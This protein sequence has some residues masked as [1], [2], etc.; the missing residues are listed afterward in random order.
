MLGVLFEDAFSLWVSLKRK[1]DGFLFVISTE[2]IDALNLVLKS[3]ENLSK[4]GDFWFT[5]SNAKLVMSVSR[6][7][8]ELA[9]FLSENPIED[10]LI[11]FNDITIFDSIDLCFLSLTRRSLCETKNGKAIS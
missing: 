9:E 1:V 4:T 6:V 7:V 10:E 2:K 11:I 3:S 5:D 8:P